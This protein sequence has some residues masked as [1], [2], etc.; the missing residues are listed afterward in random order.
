M[1]YLQTDTTTYQIDAQRSHTQSERVTFY[2][3][4]FQDEGGSIRRGLNLQEVSFTPSIE[5]V[6]TI[7]FKDVKY[8]SFDNQT[9]QKV[10]SVDF[11]WNSVP[12][13][14][15]YPFTVNMTISPLRLG[16]EHS[17]LGLWDY[18]TQS[19]SQNG[20]HNSPVKITYYAPQFYF[21]FQQSLVDFVGSSVTFTRGSTKTYNGVT[22]QANEPVFDNG[23]YIGTNDVA[24]LN[25]PSTSEGTLLLKI[26]YKEGSGD[27]NILTTSNF[28]LWIDETNQQI[29][30]TQGPNTLSVSYSTYESGGTWLVGIQWDALN[31]YLA[32]GE[33]DDTNLT[34]ISPATDSGAF[35]ISFESTYL[36]SSGTDSWLGDIISDFII[37]DYKIT[38]WTT[39]TYH[40]TLE[41][42]NWN[43]FYIS[44]QTAGKIIFEEGRLTDANGTDITGLTSGTIIELI[45]DDVQMKGGL[46]GRW[47]VEVKDCYVL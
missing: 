25:I 42:L 38:N 17:Y 11:S 18:A 7:P 47:D 5:D 26:R 46:S 14:I 40:F 21:P 30:L 12:T 34:F 2:N 39:A 41:P 33:W 32:F 43:N 36:G 35:T 27:R 13:G 31:T 45:S 8:I 3:Y 10:Y 20:N 44:N 37:Y 9:W 1:I 19:V 22:Y 15:K 4:P 23:L 28:T 29:K 16:A 24:S 6:N